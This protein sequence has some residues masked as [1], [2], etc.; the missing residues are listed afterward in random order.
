MIRIWRQSIKQTPLYGKHLALGARLIDFGGWEL[1]VQ[2]TG[3]L[4]EHQQVR[5][6]AGLFDVS[7]MGEITVNGAGATEFLDRLLTNRVSGIA[8]GRV[9]YSPMCYPDGGCVDDLLAY[10]MG[11][12]DWFLVVNASNTDKDFAWILENKPE[13]V[14]VRNV[15]ADYAQLAVQ[16]PGAMEILAAL[17]EEDLASMG[18]FRFRPRVLIAGI[19]VILSRTGYTG[20]DGF[21]LYAAA[22]DGPGLW[23]AVLEA[24]RNKGLVPVGLGARDTLRFEAALPLYG[25]E[26]SP[27]LSPVEAGLSRFIAWDKDDFIGKEALLAQK[28]AGPA[29]ILAG[30][31]MVD[32]G[33]PRNGYPILA[34]GAPAG[35]VTSGS[36]SPTLDKNL[37]MGILPAAFA[38][39]GT[40]IEIV[41]RE[42]PLKARVVPLPFYQKKYHK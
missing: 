24:G 15:S 26:L 42:K 3:I 33:I 40:D 8:E 30:F 35:F 28:A 9:V 41:I 22:G 4:E 13:G 37:G 1:P 14:E 16:G 34:G 7:H 20:E 5:E 10:R 23:D 18:F 21:E 32:R 11:P 6:A 36:V 12:E 31:E 38:A 25:H 2:Y 29:R 39:P 17:T 19:P 27:E